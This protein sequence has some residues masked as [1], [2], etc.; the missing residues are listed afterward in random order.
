ME[1]VDN[2]K[3]NIWELN[4]SLFPKEKDITNTD[5]KMHEERQS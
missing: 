3:N 4:L 1:I 2:C 5:W